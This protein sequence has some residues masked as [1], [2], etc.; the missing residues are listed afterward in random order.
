MLSLQQR[1]SYLGLILV[2]KEETLA[3]SCRLHS[4]FVSKYIKTEMEKKGGL[5]KLRGKTSVRHQTE[6]RPQQ[7]NK[8]VHLHSRLHFRFFLKEV[9]ITTQNT[10]DQESMEA[11]RFFWRFIFKMYL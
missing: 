8:K 6:R 10:T 3:A 1:Q 4:T 9:K 11:L 7:T 5:A 2:E